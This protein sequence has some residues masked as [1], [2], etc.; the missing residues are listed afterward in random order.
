M[1]DKRRTE[2]DNIEGVEISMC[3][4]QELQGN[5]KQDSLAQAVDLGGG[6]RICVWCG[7]A[8]NCP[9]E[10]VVPPS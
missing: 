3:R 10:S 6:S 9:P 5:F 8:S 4:D 7:Q 1:G 2:K